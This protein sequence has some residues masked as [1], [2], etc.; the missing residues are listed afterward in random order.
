MYLVVGANGGIG[1]NLTEQLLLCGETVNVAVACRSAD[2][3][4]KLVQKISEGPAGKAAADRILQ[5]KL[6]AT[7]PA[8]VEACVA[9]VLDKYGRIDGA[10][11]CAG[12]IILKP[13]HSTT[14][15]EF[16]QTIAT[17]LNSSFSLMRCLARPMMKQKSGSIVFCSSAV[18][19]IGLS[20]HE[21]IAAAKAGV[22]GLALSAA[23]T[24]AKFGIR[25][26]VVSPGL[27]DTKIASRITG[28]E[29][30]LKASVAMHPF[31]RI[32]QPDEVASAVLFLLR[33]PYITGQVL[34]VDG[35]LSS[36]K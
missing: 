7:V 34:G 29:A 1:S 2:S 22:A 20:N 28:N 33:H 36:L 6:D 17:N 3:M 18:A 21:A 24:Y 27:T 16:S 30:A 25:V 4:A 23:A 9:S 8:E 14:E 26:N 31:G 10:A 5:I 32:A 12:S 13:A 15:E 11:N 35:G 19:K